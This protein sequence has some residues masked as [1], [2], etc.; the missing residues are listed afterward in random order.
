M[1]TEDNSFGT[2]EFLQLCGLLNCEPYIAGNVGTGTPQEMANWIEYLNY[3]GKSTLA[4][5]RR[6]N[7]HP[8]PY[9]VSFWGVGNES[10][11]CGGDMTPE[12]YADQYKR[13]AS[14]CESYPGSPRLKKIMSGANA[15]DYN[16]TDVVY[17]KCKPRAVVGNIHALLYHCKY[18]ATQ[19]LCNK[20]W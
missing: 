1:I 4:D 17:E 3:D 12:F 13:Y 11:G 2:D 5:M 19:R 20:F 14:F 6:A 10:W 18:L 16:W 8:T 7:G 15:D 9:K